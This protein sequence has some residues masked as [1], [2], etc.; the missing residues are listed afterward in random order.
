LNRTEATAIIVR[1]FYIV[2]DSIYWLVALPPGS[3]EQGAFA[4]TRT[5]L[6]FLYYVLQYDTNAG[7]VSATPFDLE[8]SAYPSL[9]PRWFRNPY[10]GSFYARYSNTNNITAT[11]GGN[12][13][14]ASLPKIIC[15][16]SQG[17]YLWH[18]ESSG[19]T[20]TFGSSGGLDFDSDNNIYL[21]GTASN[22]ISDSF[23]G[24]T[25]PGSNTGYSTFLMKC[26]PKMTSYDWVTYHSPG[27]ANGNNQ[28][29]FTPSKIFLTGAIN[30]NPITWGT[31][32]L[33]GPGPN[34][35]FDPLL[36]SF[37]P[38]TGDCTGLYRLPGSNGY[39]DSFTSIT[40]DNAGDIILGGFMG[41]DLTDANGIT[42]YTNG[43]NSDFFITKFASQNCTPLHTN[44]F[45]NSHILV[46][47]N[48]VKEICTVAIDYKSPF[49]IYNLL[50]VEVLKGVIDPTKQTINL[51][52]LSQ[53]FYL[54]QINTKTGEKTSVKIF[55]E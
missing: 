29:L 20:L 47:P 37:D 28:V 7:F 5:D 33:A 54:L 14:N 36:A 9:A 51:S 40:Q 32:T 35:S 41:L 16:N 50:G 22:F 26:N 46:F 30:Q 53:G 39:Q 44:V 52:G 18:R 49:K 42:H 19:S 24:W 17:Q 12:S 8:L 1:N 13:L 34:N 4:N 10:N 23:L 15:F 2:N 11:A 6:P 31:Q 45:E 38:Q 43:G 21:A 27:S 3:Y 48:P 25:L 55:K